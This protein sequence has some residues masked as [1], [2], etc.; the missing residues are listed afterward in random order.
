MQS[1]MVDGRD[2][3]DFPF[4]IGS[5]Q[6]REVVITLSNLTTNLS[7]AVTDSH[8]APSLNHTVVVFAVDDRFW[9]TRSRR[10]LID[11]PD[12]R[13]QYHFSG[14][15]AGDYFVALTAPDLERRPPSSLLH[16][17]RAASKRVTLR[18]GEPATLNLRSSPAA[19][20][21]EEAHSFSQA[22]V[23]SFRR[24]VQHTTGPR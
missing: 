6:H 9:T 7:G 17:L 20:V 19:R 23:S 18:D 16:S 8:G 21:S 3:L 14:L 24:T 13:G 2:A 5:D 11:R 4:E 1:E 22:S 12:T 15:P 10:I